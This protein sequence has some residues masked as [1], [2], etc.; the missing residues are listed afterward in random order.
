MGFITPEDMSKLNLVLENLIILV[1]LVIQFISQLIKKN[2]TISE[3]IWVV[4]TDK[5]L[6]GLKNYLI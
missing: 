5:F 4:L 1:L 2:T 6:R 3:L